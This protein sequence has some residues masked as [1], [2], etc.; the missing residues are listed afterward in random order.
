MENVDEDAASRYSLPTGAYVVKVEPDSAA[1]KAGIQ[2]KDII[3]DVG[4]HT[5]SNVTDLT[6]ALRNFKAGDTTTV[7]V[8]R[9]GSNVTMEITLDEKPQDTEAQTQQPTQNMPNNGDFNEWY[10]FFRRYFGG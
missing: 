9:G 5:V 2:V 6:R 1:K 7:T 10:D 3:T 4:G 8:V